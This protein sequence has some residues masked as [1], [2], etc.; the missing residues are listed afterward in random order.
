MK[1]AKLIREKLIEQTAFLRF[2]TRT[3]NKLLASMAEGRVD[4][5][6]WCLGESK[7]RRDK[8]INQAIQ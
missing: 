7:P 6:A 8:R 2:F 5:L 4:T 3:R 1:P